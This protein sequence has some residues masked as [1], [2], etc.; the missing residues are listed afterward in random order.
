MNRFAR[1]ITLIEM[2]ISISILAIALTGVTVMLGG[3]LSNSSDTLLEVRAVALGQAYLDEIIGKRFDE[4]TRDSGI[5]PCRNNAG[6]PRACSSTLGPEAGESRASFDDVDD[7]NGL[8][9]G[10]GASNATLRDALGNVRTG[11][12]NFRVTVA[13]R[14]IAVG[15]GETEAGLAIANELDD[16]Q[17]A[18]LVSV[19]VSH[20]G[21]SQGIVF[22]AYKSNY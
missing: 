11:F 1:G 5:P 2:V 16:A 17:D 4:N 19:T 8:D 20:R 3:S 18:K 22:S 15:A 10:L 13:V 6:S 7:Y 9:E 14:A 12:D 21:L